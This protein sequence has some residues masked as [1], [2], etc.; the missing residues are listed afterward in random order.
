[1]QAE[2]IG[3]GEAARLLDVSRATIVRWVH[4]G[5]LRTVGKIAGQR[6]GFLFERSYIE[7]RADAERKA[8]S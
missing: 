5:T 8:A 6:G 3:T 2:V 7:G 1:M 4:A